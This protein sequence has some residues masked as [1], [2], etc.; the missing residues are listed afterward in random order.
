MGNRGGLRRYPVCMNSPLS[1]LLLVSLIPTFA[2]SVDYKNDILPI[3]KERCWDC[4]S[5]DKDVKG[6]LALDD[7]DE[8]RDYQIGKYNIIRPGNPDESNFLERLKLDSS[9]NDF[10]P[11]KAA[12]IPKGEVEKIE[13]WIRLGAVIDAKNPTEDESEW[14]KKSDGKPGGEKG[15]TLGKTEPFTW[16]SSDGKTIQARFLALEGESVSLLL[17]NG[18]KATVPLSRLNSESQEQAKKLSG[19]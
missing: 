2:W 14:L 8:V 10:M 6:N 12:P 19:L 18:K 15:E 11:R 13:E 9:H 1:T 4:H 17:E 5:N 3:M 16:T 7:L